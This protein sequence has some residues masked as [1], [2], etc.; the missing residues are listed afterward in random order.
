MKG[1][2]IRSPWIDLILSGSKTWEMRTRPTSI[3]GPIA[4][5]KGGSGLIYGTA[6]LAECLPALTRE[7]MRQTQSFHAIPEDQL[8]SAMGNR[9]TTPWVLRD[10]V[11]LE[12]PK[13][14]IHPKGAVTWVE[15]PD[16]TSETVSKNENQ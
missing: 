3:R 1:L 6:E 12:S 7:Q 5:I 15:L 4:L 10:I 2:I 14:Y 9:W 16:E 8:E 11:R 13:P